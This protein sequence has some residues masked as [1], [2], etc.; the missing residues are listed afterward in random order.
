MRGGRRSSRGSRLTAIGFTALT[1]ALLL[2]DAILYAEAA[3]TALSRA[4]VHL[5]D[6]KVVVRAPVY[7]EAEVDGKTV[8]AGYGVV[9]APLGARIRPCLLA[10]LLTLPCSLDTHE[11][12]NA[13]PNG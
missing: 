3:C 11:Y 4:S 5:V 2:L 1:V 13:S 9:E 12:E 7:M 6:G 8:A 10:C